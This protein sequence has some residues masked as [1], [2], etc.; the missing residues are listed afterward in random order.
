MCPGP[1][2]PAPWRSESLLAGSSGKTPSD[3]LRAPGAT[4]G[5][6]LTRTFSHPKAPHNMA[7]R[8][9]SFSNLQERVVA[10]QVRLQLIPESSEPELDL[11]QEGEEPNGGASATRLYSGS[12]EMSSA[13]P[14]S[15][16]VSSAWRGFYLRTC[17][18]ACSPF[19]CP[20]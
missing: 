1:V 15:L 4:A 14:I 6:I 9:R 11:V 12:P 19:P 20:S 5:L 3:L 7:C 18:L 16:K 17:S 8:M 2:L 13:K 10:L